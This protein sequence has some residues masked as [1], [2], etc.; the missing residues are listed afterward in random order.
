MELIRELLCAQI[1]LFHFENDIDLAKIEQTITDQY[2]LV[3]KEIK[4]DKLKT[5]GSDFYNSNSD[6]SLFYLF[7]NAFQY[8]ICNEDAYMDIKKIFFEMFNCFEQIVFFCNKIVISIEAVVLDYISFYK[9]L[10]QDCDY[11]KAAY[12][13]LKSSNSYQM[14]NIFVPLEHIA[15]RIQ[16]VKCVT[17]EIVSKYTP[18]Q[19][20]F[21][22]GHIKRLRKPM[23]LLHTS[24]PQLSS[25]KMYVI[26]SFKKVEQTMSGRFMMHTVKQTHY[27]SWKNDETKKLF[28]KSYSN[29]LALCLCCK[30]VKNVFEDLLIKLRSMMHEI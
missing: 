10:M 11:E 1:G 30:D 8:A 22:T 24:L 12:A 27:K 14:E 4:Y 20:N 6:I 23:F 28:L 15:S 2:D 25:S 16:S 26:E 18:F 19:E 3:I 5:L 13:I 9:C 17:E 21:Q 29:L 7:Q